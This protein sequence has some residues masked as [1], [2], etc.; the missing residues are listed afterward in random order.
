MKKVKIGFVGCGG[1]ANMV[2]YPSLSEIEDVEI[3]AICDIDREKLKNT[4]E[5]YKIEKRYTEYKK[6]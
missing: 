6:C 4:G 5:K 3:S 1:F 2:H